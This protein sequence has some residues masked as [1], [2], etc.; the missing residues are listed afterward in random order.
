MALKI[1]IVGLPNVGK[2][3]LFNA[4]TRTKSAQAENYPFCTIDPNIG[5]VEVPDQRLNHL[6]ETSKSAKIIPTA[7]EFVDIAG[8]VKGAS[9]GEGLGNKFL[10]NIRECD[11]IG[12]VVRF[13]ED[14]NVTHVHTEADPKL[15]REVIESELLLA[16]L[17]TMEKRIDKASSEA[18]SG[19]KEKIQYAALLNRVAD[20]MKS[21]TLAS[22]LSF[23]E[24]EE[25]MLRD[26]HL[27]TMKP[28]M[29][30]IN[31]HEDELSSGINVQEYAKNLGLDSH[32]KIV[33]ICAKVE[34]ELSDFGPEEAREY[35]TSLG[36]DETGLNLL[37][38]KAYDTLGLITFFTSGPQETRAWTV[39]KGAPAPKAAGKIHTDFETGFIKAEVVG[40][41]DLH[42]SGGEGKARDKGL[43]RIEG[44]DYEVKDGDVMH[45]RFSP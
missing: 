12:H 33:P 4:L 38:R 36:L 40:W 31:L 14:P 7:I 1:G 22:N 43:L 37:I 21:G 28:H 24:E 10:S 26:L 2:S 25:E 42:K 13:F 8:L 5:V 19:N 41:E 23:E 9:S 27:L 32:D 35:L 11:T 20:E 3:T 15:D 6:A 44:K 18:K 45:F 29:Y 39:Q 34:E 16:D 17:Q 30:I